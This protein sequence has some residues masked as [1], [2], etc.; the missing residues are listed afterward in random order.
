VTKLE[1]HPPVC[2]ALRQKRKHGLEKM[3]Q[4]GSGR[5][6]VVPYPIFSVQSVSPGGK[7]V[8]ANAPV[9]GEATGVSPATMAIPVDGGSPPRICASYCFPTWSSNGEFLFVPVEEPSRTSA[10]RSLAIPAGPGENWPP[11]PP[12]GIEPQAPVSVMPGSQLVNRAELVAGKDPDHFAY[13]NTTVHRNLYRIS[14]P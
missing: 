8:I 2:N 5:S 13:V 14:L 11:F 12:G 4:D 9:P 3:N 10:G 7:W 6:K 1:I